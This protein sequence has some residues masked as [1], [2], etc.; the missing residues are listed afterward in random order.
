LADGVNSPAPQR[1]ERFGGIGRA[2]SSRDYRLYALGHFLH[3]HGWWGNRVAVGWLTWQLTGSNKWVGIMTLAA[4]VPIM[5]VAPLA[6]A[7]ADRYGHRRT[8]M[9]AGM[10]GAVILS[11]IAVL[12]LTGEITLHLLLALTIIQGLLFGL[13]FP[14]RQALIPILVGKANIAAAVAFNSTTFQLGAFL[15]PALAAFLISTFNPGASILVYAGTTLWMFF[16]LFLIRLEKPVPREGGA[17]SLVSDMRAG[18]GYVWNEKV[19]RY[20]LIATITPGFFLRPYIDLLPGFADDVFNRGEVGLGMLNSASGFGALAISLWL[21]IRGKSQ[22]LVIIL[23][24]SAVLTGL[25]LIG[26]TQVSVFTFAL[27]VL[28]VTAGALL[29]A[30]VSAYSLVQTFTASEMR[31]RVIAINIAINMGGPALGAF[32]IGWFGD[33]IGLTNSVAVA[34]IVALGILVFVVPALMRRRQ[35]IEAE[36]T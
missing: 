32:V 9:T 15:G 16:M 21:L 25:S 4:M 31:G 23:A 26:F 14:A 17:A 6:G 2:L 33:I 7:V 22:G 3:V 28:A 10:C 24:A 30:Q 20:L 36:G 34:S 1:A 35:T 12:A 13:E 18:F 29:A 11:I 27:P 5:V 19:L 8:A